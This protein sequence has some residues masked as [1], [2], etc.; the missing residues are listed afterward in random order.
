[1]Q[2][3]WGGDAGPYCE[4]SEAEAEVARWGVSA[5]ALWRHIVPTL[6]QPVHMSCEGTLVVAHH[7]DRAGMRHLAERVE[8]AGFG[9]HLQWLRRDELREL[10]PELE[11]R[12]GEGLYLSP[13]GE[14]DP[15]SLLPSL[16]ETLRQNGATLCFETEVQDLAPEI[17]A[18]GRTPD[19]RLGID[20][21]G[22]AASDQMTTVGVRGEILALRTDE[23]RLR[24]PIRMMHPRYPLYIVPS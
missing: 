6:A 24:R 17:M 11:G 10:E 23:V 4:L 3:C 13:E 5:L 20:C 21:R 19:L 15:R 2:P 9:A 1:M 16:V 14:I 7:R 22:L 8:H 12:F 18:L